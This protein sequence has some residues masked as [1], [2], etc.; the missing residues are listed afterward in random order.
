[1]IELSEELKR[2]RE[3]WRQKGFLLPNDSA[4]KWKEFDFKFCG[5]EWIAEIR[6]ASSGWWDTFLANGNVRTS[7][8]SF[9]KERYLS[10]GDEVLVAK[11][12]IFFKWIVTWASFKL[13]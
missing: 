9:H 3:I 6:I 7:A 1:M 10:K 2:L 13:K 4:S 11:Q 5:R 12:I 8:I